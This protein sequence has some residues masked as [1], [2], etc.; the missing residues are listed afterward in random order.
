MN[1]P[2]APRATL[3]IARFTDADRELWLTSATTVLSD[4]EQDWVSKTRDADLRTQHAVGRALLRLIGG[5][6][7]GRPARTLRVVVSEVG[8]PALG[9]AVN[10]HLSVAHTTGVVAVAAAAAAVG[11]DIEPVM[12][13]GGDQ[14]RLAQRLF[15]E[16]EVAALEQVGEEELADWFARMWT[17]KEAVGKALGV[18]IVPALAGAVLERRD[19][20]FALRSMWT[21][22]PAERWT[23][24]QLAAPGQGERIAVAVAAPEVELEPPVLLCL[25]DFSRDCAVAAKLPPG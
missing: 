10:V 19:G 18:G 1:R 11:V 4:A 13:A 3:T 8:Q 22:P 23:L 24:H 25:A 16:P 2:A 14:R 21:D 15:A 6:A 7:T 9:D 12:P 17:I 20:R 5:R